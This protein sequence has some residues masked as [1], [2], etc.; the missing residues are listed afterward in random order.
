MEFKYQNAP[1]SA[2]HLI[3]ETI[4]RSIELKHLYRLIGSTGVGKT[5]NIKL[6][7]SERDDY[8]FISPRPSECSKPFFSRG[9]D[10]IFNEEL[11]GN[12]GTNGVNIDDLIENLSF[13]II[14]RNIKIVIIDEAGNLKKNAQSHLRQLW[15]NIKPYCG[16]IVAGPDR[17][18]LNLIEWNRDLSSG[19]P[20]WVSRMDDKYTIE[21]PSLADIKMICKMNQVESAKIIRYIE[22]NTINLSGIKRIVEAF[23]RG[24]EFD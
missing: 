9:L 14:D 23:H 18:D 17:Y 22:L 1:V 3:T 21:R 20:E 16:M 10:Q 15:D 11:D 4:D 7:L 8:F 2:Y 12:V 19:I 5:T 24:E 13:E 6:V